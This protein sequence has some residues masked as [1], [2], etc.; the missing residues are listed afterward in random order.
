VVLASPTMGPDDLR[1]RIQE[2]EATV[3][4]LST[5]LQ[6]A[7][8]LITQI[9]VDGKFLYLNHVSPGFRLEDVLGTSAEAYIPEAFR[10]RAHA[11]MRA[12]RETRS[13]QQFATLG[14]RTSAEIGHYL[15][16]VSPVVENGEVTS[17]V[18]I[19]T[20]VTTLEEQRIQL[21]VA[22]DA[23]GMGIWTHDPRNDKGSWDAQ[24][25]RI[26]GVADDAP[27]PLKADVLEK[28]VHPDD[29]ARV[30]SSLDETTTT[31]RYGPIQHRILRPNGEVRWVSASGLA[32]RNHEGGIERII[33]STQ[34]VTERR[35]LEERLLE[36]QK[37]E[38]IGRLAG[39]VAHDF[40]N[41]LTAIFGNLQFLDEATSLEEARPLVGEIRLI[42]ERSAA[43]TAQLLAF[44]RRQVIEPKVL[45]PNELIRRLDRVFR[46]AIGENVRVV[47]A[48]T[49]R[50]H[51]RAD[52]SQLEQVVMNLVTNARDAMPNGGVLTL[53]TLDVTLD[54]HYADTHAEVTPGPYVMVGVSDTGLGIPPEAL[55]HVFEPFFTTRVG[56]TGLGLATCYG[57]VKQSGGH[58]SVYSESGR[59]T[60]FKVYLPCIDADVI[61]DEQR[62]PTPMPGRGERVL[63]VEDEA[64]VRAVIER[65]LRKHG[66][67]VTSVTTAEEALAIVQREPERAFALLVSDVVL[68]GMSGRA[69]SEE[70]AKLMPKMSVLFISG[71]TENAIVH[72]GVLDAGI[73]FL[74]KPFLPA[75]LLRTV[76]AVLYPR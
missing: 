16:R 63:L 3:R 47:L 43:L 12:A 23:G 1:V 67:E 34:D 35:L 18:M 57:I 64:P 31:G 53:E 15:T 21:Q 22:L 40:N 76:Q 13:V 7:P 8:D 26:F 66:Y 25:R 75:D 30:R 37:L 56:G 10:E 11:A 28:Y 33:G 42:A 9:T 70:L 17:L 59:G 41:M 55:P 5:M 54:R 2:L 52:E 19:A 27:P 62:A 38:S 60:T 45:D 39:G 20:D 61:R 68:P 24:T 58:L 36:A 4:V 51:I 6:S 48:L 74:Q 44:A 29:R 14:P 73:H 49:A 50:G 46:R 72:G 71:Y 65:T 69:L 32:V